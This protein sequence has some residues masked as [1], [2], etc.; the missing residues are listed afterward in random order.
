MTVALHAWSARLLPRGPIDLAR[1]LVLIGLLLVVYEHVRVLSASDANEAFEHARELI[2]LERSLHIFVEPN[3]QAWASSTRLLMDCADWLYLNAQ[4]SIIVGALT[5]IYRFRN[6]SFYFVRNMLFIAWGMALVGYSVFPTAP[7]R[8]L[9]E[10]GFVDSVTI[11]AHVH[12][13]SGGLISLVNPYAAVPSMHVGLAVVIAWPM[14]RLVRWRIARMLWLAYPLLI[15][16]VTVVTA[17]HL[18]IDAMLGALTAGLAAYGAQ[19]LARARPQA[20]RFVMQ[21]CP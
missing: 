1:Q 10:W 5:Y 8:L 11:F 15:A 6:A 16:F 18:L 2:S 17:N 4:T 3:L 7:P 13:Q 21:P 12:A 19:S 14:A 9:P 20:W